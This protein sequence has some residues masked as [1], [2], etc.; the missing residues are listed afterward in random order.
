MIVGLD[1]PLEMTRKLA[2]VCRVLSV[3]VHFS[4]FSESLLV[5]FHKL[6]E[7]DEL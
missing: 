1:I 6:I 7:P 2:K 3:Y 4:A 5:N